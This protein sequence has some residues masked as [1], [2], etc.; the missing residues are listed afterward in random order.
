M[1]EIYKLFTSNG[2]NLGKKNTKKFFAL[3]DADS[4]GSLTI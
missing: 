2:I 3:L 4:S 1:E